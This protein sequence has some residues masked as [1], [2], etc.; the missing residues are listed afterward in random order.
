VS[1]GH[2]HD[3]HVTGRISGEQHSLFQRDRLSP[4]GP[5]NAGRY[6]SCRC[7]DRG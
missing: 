5:N 4:R 1:P 3:A 2:S 7:S 6:R